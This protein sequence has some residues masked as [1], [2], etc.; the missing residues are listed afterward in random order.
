MR[1][2]IGVESLVNSILK[3]ERKG[4]FITELVECEGAYLMIEFLYF[5]CRST[6]CFSISCEDTTNE[7]NENWYLLYY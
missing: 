2:Q 6:K 7:I 4:F 3:E 1:L 5:K